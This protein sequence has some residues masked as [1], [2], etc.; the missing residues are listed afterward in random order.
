MANIPKAVRVTAKRH[1]EASRK[2]ESKDYPK[3]SKR[4]D[5]STGNWPEMS[6]NEGIKAGGYVANFTKANSP[7]AAPRQFRE[8]QVTR[9]V[10]PK[11]GTPR[12][13]IGAIRGK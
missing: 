5:K 7:T 6:W 10:N 12:T 13:I 11:T 3:L 9:T 4:T 1:A 2:R 8:V